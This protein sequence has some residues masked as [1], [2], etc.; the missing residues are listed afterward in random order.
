MSASAGAAGGRA[1]LVDGRQERGRRGRPR[2]LE[3]AG[4]G[5]RRRGRRHDA[6]CTG[7]RTATIWPRPELLVRAGANVKAVEPLRGHAAVF[8]RRQRQRGD[9]RA[10]AQGRRRCQHGAAGRRD[11]ADDG[12]AHRQGRRHEGAAGARRQRQRQGTLEAADGAD[13]GRARRQRRGGEAARRAGANI[14]DRSIFGWTPLLFA[15]RQGQVEAIKALARRRRQRQRHPAGRHQRAGHRRSGPQLR[16]RR[17]PAGARRR[18]QRR[19]PGLDGLAPDG[20]VAAAAAWSEQSRPEAA[21]QSEQPRPGEEARRARRR[22]Q[23]PRD[24]GTQLGHGRPE[25]LEPVRRHAVLPGRQVVRCPDD[26]GAARPRRR[27]VH[28]QRR[29]R[30]AADGGRRRRRL[31]SG[32]KPGRAR[33]IGR[34]RED[35]AGPRRPGRTISTGTARRRCTA[36]PGEDRTRR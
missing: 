12:G 17:R 33:G 8:R 29:R 13:V 24:E 15:A 6:R 14:G 7:R 28:R 19:R 4:R 26:A 34:G 27:S 10:A 22:H 31:L 21:G 25:Q 11:G 36:R 5:E 23:C 30:H 16:G 1:S 2:P 18:S 9:D 20:V 35:A 3:A 32:R